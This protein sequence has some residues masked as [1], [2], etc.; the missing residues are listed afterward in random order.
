MTT[1]KLHCSLQIDRMTP[2]HEQPGASQGNAFSR[3]TTGQP[4][5]FLAKPTKQTKA[6][7]AQAVLNLQRVKPRPP[8]KAFNFAAGKECL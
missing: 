7:H 5:V 6:E 8:G 3:H 4:S 2:Y 1:N